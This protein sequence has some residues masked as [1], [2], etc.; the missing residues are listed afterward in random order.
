MAVEKTVSEAIHYRRSVRVF[1]N[2]A[3]DEEKVKQCLGLATLAA[4]SS[5]MQLWEFYHIVDSDKI[6]KRNITVVTNFN[7]DFYINNGC[8]CA[9]LTDDFLVND[10]IVF[11]Q[12]KN[13]KYFV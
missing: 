8:C 12:I 3:I 10:F 13:I 9:S 4:T 7:N 6:Q 2:E 11:A 5:N 1:K